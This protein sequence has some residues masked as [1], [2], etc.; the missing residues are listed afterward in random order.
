MI[1]SVENFQPPL[2]PFS[3][4]LE[5]SHQFNNI[6][7]CLQSHTIVW[8]C[9]FIFFF[10]FFFTKNAHFD[11]F[12]DLFVSFLFLVFVN[13]SSKILNKFFFVNIPSDHTFFWRTCWWKNN[14]NKKKIYTRVQ[15]SWKFPAL[16]MGSLFWIFYFCWKTLK[17]IIKNN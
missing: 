10:N 4:S 1:F 13:I 9:L 17:Q 14:K 3:K 11:W 8:I 6:W 2:W 7:S 16:N 5:I 12:A 15:S